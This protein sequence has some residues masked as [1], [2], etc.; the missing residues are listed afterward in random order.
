MIRDGETG[1]TKVSSDMT[2]IELILY[3]CKLLW[4]DVS[5]GDTPSDED[6]RIISHALEDRGIDP[7]EIFSY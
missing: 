2:D 1:M 6:F 7:D 5:D 3:L 4:D